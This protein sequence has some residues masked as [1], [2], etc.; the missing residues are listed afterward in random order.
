MMKCSQFKN[1]FD[2]YSNMPLAPELS[3]GYSNW[4]NHKNSCDDFDRNRL[5]PLV[6]QKIVGSNQSQVNIGTF[7]DF[8]N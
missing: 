8:S 1:S 3:A 2:K 6:R 4:C 5:L 7:H